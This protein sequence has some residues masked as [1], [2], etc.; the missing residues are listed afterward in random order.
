MDV[1]SVQDRRVE[2]V[3]NRR[4]SEV[5]LALWRD[6][7]INA[8][9]GVDEF[10]ALADSWAQI[11]ELEE[12]AARERRRESYDRMMRLWCP[13][14]A[15][16]QREG[17]APPLQTPAERV[18]EAAAGSGDPALRETA[19]AIPDR[20]QDPGDPS[21]VCAPVRDD[22][23]EAVSESDH[24]MTEGDGELEP[25]PAK[26]PNKARVEAGV[27]GMATR[28]QNILAAL[29]HARAD[30]ISMQRV[31]DQVGGLTINSV[32]DVL[33]AKNLPLPVWTD[34]EK[35]LKKLGYPPAAEAAGAKEADA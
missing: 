19:E 16:E 14:T 9:I 13:E 26:K 11:R 32:M 23:A 6:R 24:P 5:F 12:I 7:T 2:R 27:K 34:V 10:A 29:R 31:A 35:A 4:P 28:K 8:E 25:T 33:D 21:P 3:E 18:S 22:S 15:P 1:E 17:Q 20:V 30:G